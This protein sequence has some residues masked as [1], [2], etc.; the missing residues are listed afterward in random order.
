MELQDYG[1]YTIIL[2]EE[3]WGSYRSINLRS[4]ITESEIRLIDVKPMFI[5]CG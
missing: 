3:Y 5:R 2:S 4:K 1:N